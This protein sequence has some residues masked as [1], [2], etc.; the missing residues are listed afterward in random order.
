MPAWVRDALRGAASLALAL[1]IAGSAAADDTSDLVSKNAFRVCADPANLP[2]SNTEG[3]GF[4]NRIAELIAGK[5]GLPVEYAW[6]PQATGFVRNTLFA[7]KCDVIMGYAQGDELVLNTNHYY[8]SAYALVT[9]ADGPLAGVDA[10]SDPRLQGKAVGVVAGS[11]PG[12]HMARYGLM[13]KARPYP[14]MVD[15]RYESP[16]E[17]MLEDV[18]SGVTDAAILWGPIAGWIAQ[19][20]D[21]PMT[22]TPLLKEDGSPRLFYRI[23][24]GVRQGEVTWKRD[25]NSLIRRNQAEID[26]ILREYG[27]PLVDL[28]GRPVDGGGTAQ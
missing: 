24:M 27:V 4:E 17:R 7:A 11:P 14:L 20:S 25:L 18:A 1:G 22:V 3:E 15:R 16:A 10:L 26:A 21:V 19:K 13:G 6:F 28:Y 5:M 12:D 9:K 2:F 8:V 23:T